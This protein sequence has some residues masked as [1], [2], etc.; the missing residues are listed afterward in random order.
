MLRECE[1][2]SQFCLVPRS[3]IATKYGLSKTGLGNI[4]L[5]RESVAAAAKD[6]TLMR[7]KV[8]KL[9]LP[10]VDSST[11]IFFQEARAKVYLYLELF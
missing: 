3:V 4:W 10:T 6:G 5:N 11:L 1:Y 2:F 9:K 8:L 7:K